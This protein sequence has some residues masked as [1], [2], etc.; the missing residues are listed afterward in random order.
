MN[1]FLRFKSFLAAFTLGAFLIVSLGC[2]YK[3]SY[4]RESKKAEVANRWIVEKIDL[5]RLSADEA[6]IYQQMGPPQ[7]I[8]FYRTIAPERRRVYEWVYSEPIRLVFFIDGK[9]VEYVPVDDDPSSLNDRERKR[10][11]Y[12][13]VGTLVVGGLGILSY[14]LFGKK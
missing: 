10:L 9:K 6:A 8:R 12:G 5:G 14:Y 4:L 7:Y 13:S 2:G 11:L 1:S 3:P